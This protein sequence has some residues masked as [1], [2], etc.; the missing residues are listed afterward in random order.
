[1]HGGRY[2]RFVIR[3]NPT[4]PSAFDGYL[5]EG[6]HP[7][8]LKECPKHTRHC[9]VCGDEMI[10]IPLTNRWGQTYRWR[11]WCREHGHATRDGG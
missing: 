4:M 11:A 10:W 6:R 8:I 2:R 5:P 1:M 3:S 9:K 7:A